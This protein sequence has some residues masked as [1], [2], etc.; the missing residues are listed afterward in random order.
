VRGLG[1]WYTTFPAVTG[2]KQL[3]VELFNSL[4]LIAGGQSCSGKRT[5]VSG[6][7]YSGLGKAGRRKS[8]VARQEHRVQWQP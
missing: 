1:R 6:S 8:H 7:R 4:V 5:E 2:G 3:T